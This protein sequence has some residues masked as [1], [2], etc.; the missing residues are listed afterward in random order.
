M[1]VRTK[2]NRATGYGGRSENGFIEWIG[3]KDNWLRADLDHGGCA[4]FVHSVQL[5]IGDYWR[6]PILIGFSLEP[7]LP[8]T[9]S[10]D[11][12]DTIQNPGSVNSIDPAFIKEW[13]AIAGG[14]FAGLPGHGGRLDLRAWSQ[15][16]HSA[17]RN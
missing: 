13:R 16:Q 2:I 5:T 1:L 7:L 10:I 4:A 15:S 17:S 6:S 12:I 14:Q 8:E 9:L 11:R 3:R